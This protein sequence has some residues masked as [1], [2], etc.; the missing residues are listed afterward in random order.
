MANSPSGLNADPKF[1][2]QTELLRSIVSLQ[3]VPNAS[4]YIDNTVAV[5][6]NFYAITALGADGAK[7]D[8]TDGGT[9]KC[10][11]TNTTSHADYDADIKI[12]SG[13]TIFV[14]MSKVRLVSGQCIAYKR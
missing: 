3:T 4:V 11:V 2:I 5:T 7:L 8:F 9:D 14:P 10:I 12:A 1:T 13:T 6:G